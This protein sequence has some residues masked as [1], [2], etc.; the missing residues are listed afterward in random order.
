LGFAGNFLGWNFDLDFSFGRAAGFSG[1]HSVLLFVAILSLKRTRERRQTGKAV[2]GRWRWVVGQNGKGERFLLVA[3][4]SLDRC[5][6]VASVPL[7]ANLGHPR[8]EYNSLSSG[9]V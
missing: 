9:F 1:A 4:G 8:V 2:V 6:S 7:R 3:R 5:P